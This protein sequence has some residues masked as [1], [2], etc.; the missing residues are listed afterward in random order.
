[1]VDEQ[2]DDWA[3]LTPEQLAQRP[4][5]ADDSL[6]AASAGD[7]RV[8]AK[9]APVAPMPE[10]GPEKPLSPRAEKL[11]RELQ[12]R[13]AKAG[14]GDSLIAH[15]QHRELRTK[16][17]Q[18]AA[19]K[20]AAQLTATCVVGELPAEPEPV[21]ELSHKS[22]L[23]PRELEGWFQQLPE[24]EQS[25]L[26]AV[27]HA[28]RHKF[29]H[30]G[31]AWRSR[32]KRAAAY[33]TLSFAI[34]GLLMSFLLMDL[35]VLVRCLIVGPVAGMAAQLLG[36]ERFVYDMLGLFGFVVAVGSGIMLPFSWYG[37]IFCV[38]TM[39]ALGMDGEM[40]RS[41]GCGDD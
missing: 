7:G 22:D 41:A 29:D 20:V 27:W 4:W 3:P 10:R 33:G 15:V 32:M 11:V 16:R 1:M 6:V 17:K 14:P 36:G 2:E 23:D 31:K 30:T 5:E 24:A 28:G 13:V 37:M 9:P 18:Q 35:M 26:R 39:A 38:A 25:R 8:P 19:R 12:E 40:R 21:L 34:T